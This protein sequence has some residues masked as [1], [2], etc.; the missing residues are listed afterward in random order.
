[1]G[2][3]GEVAS[4]TGAATVQTATVRT[5]TYALKCDSTSAAAA[6]SFTSVAAGA[7]SR[8][9]FMALRFF[10]NFSTLPG[11]SSASANILASFST[12]TAP[13][14]GYRLVMTGSA[15]ATPSTLAVVNDAGGITT[16]TTQLQANTWYEIVVE[17]TA[18]A[19]IN[20]YLNGVLEATRSGGTATTATTTASLGI[21]GGSQGVGVA[22]FDDVMVG[23]APFGRSPYPYSK[24]RVLLP[25]ADPGTLNSWTNGGGGT[26]SIFEG[27]NNI[28]PTG[29][30]L[31][32]DGTKIKNAATG[33]NLDYTPTMQTY[34]AAGVPSG[35]VVNAVMAICNHGEEATTGTKAG[36]VWIASNPAQ[37]AGSGTFDYGNDT[38]TAVGTFPTGWATAVGPVTASPSVTLGTAPTMTVRKTGS[39]NRV[40][41]VDFMGIY[42]DYTPP[43]A[44][45]VN[46][47]ITTAESVTV[48]VISGDVKTFSATD[49][50]SV[51]ES[52]SGQI[53]TAQSVSDSATVAESITPTLVS[54]VS[55]SDSAT[56]AENL[57][58]RSASNVSVSDAATATESASATLNTSASV[59]DPVAVTES[60]TPSVQT[61]ISATEATTV[62][63]SVTATVNTSISISDAST[64]TESA[65]S[66][67]NTAV[68]VNDASTGT[69]NTAL[70]IQTAAAGTLTVFDASTAAESATL[71]VQTTATAT[72]TATA[73]ESVSSA[74]RVLP[75]VTDS[76]TATESASAR[77]NTSA[78]VVDTATASESVQNAV[79]VRPSVTDAATVAESRTT[80][81]NTTPSVS[82]AATVTENT[83]S[84]VNTTASVS[85]AASVT[86][87]ATPAVQT[88]ISATDA[89]TVTESAQA[90]VLTFAV[91]S[92]AVSA[93][94]WTA[95][96]VLA[97]FSVT[98]TA[99]V[100]ELVDIL[101]TAGL[102]LRV[103]DDVAVTES[104]SA[105]L[106]SYISVVDVAAVVE[107]ISAG[108]P[109]GTGWRGTIAPAYAIS[110]SLT[111]VTVSAS[112]TAAAAPAATLT[113]VSAPAAIIT[114]AEI[115]AEIEG[116]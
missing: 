60:A 73:T 45:S 89:A 87:S 83:S 112:I 30:A 110:A 78:S 91:V 29:V 105:G 56:T 48:S 116:I 11:G 84:T 68:E 49:T 41:D 65:P 74:V 80:Q 7:V 59:L 97:Y 19:V 4:S 33:S 42:V 17:Y 64:A 6:V 82:D 57:T 23:D 75:S 35:S 21:F 69:E 100:A 95:A 67:V 24:Q 26:T 27:V 62:T 109:D 72:D 16:G 70:T 39:T 66:T 8:S 103:S 55:A 85:D 40:V 81:V 92:D 54:F 79:N 93:A 20:C 9:N 12:S 96:D 71:S 102:A 34:T 113:A 111:G 90:V 76:A 94:E 1:M 61:T 114:A 38:A 37:A 88:R 18:A 5:G 15:N 22:Y 2:S 36:D 50:V 10:V 77:L 106:L 101:S 14:S 104:A 31:F 43:P 28:P 63:D 99:S 44:P 32:I 25:T 51:T 52:A 115:V 47:T 107:R 13:V 86:E 3:L 108:K 98:D 46:D 58:A 53:Q